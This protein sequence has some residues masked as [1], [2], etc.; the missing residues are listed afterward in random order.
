MLLFLKLFV[1]YIVTNSEVPNPTEF[2]IYV[3]ILQ[4]VVKSQLTK[5][6][7]NVV[8]IFDKGNK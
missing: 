7:C 6:A 8:W 1:N 2:P 4:E 3:S 5:L